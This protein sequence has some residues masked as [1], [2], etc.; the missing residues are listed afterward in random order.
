LLEATDETNARE[1]QEGISNRKYG[2]VTLRFNS[3]GLTQKQPTPSSI[4]NYTGL[5]AAGT[6]PPQTRPKSVSN[7][8]V[9]HEDDFTNSLRGNTPRHD[10]QAEVRKLQSFHQNKPVPGE[11][12]YAIQSQWITN[13]LLFVSKH[14]GKAEYAPGEI[15]NM[16]LI[17]DDLP[18][19]V[20]IVRP[21]LVLKKDFRMINKRSWDFYVAQY[22]GGPA[23]EVPVPRDCPD[24]TKWLTSL[25]LDEAG[26]VGS[27]Y[28]SS[29]S[30][31]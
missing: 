1:A 9:T 22:G 20:F 10:V 24:T 15:D 12:W 31:S 16:P 8:S 14:R 2:K 19:G 30:E 29:D 11:V 18:N 4:E 3:Y 5:M 23:I 6:P 21:N 27:G 17:S 7:G 28:F 13:W 25:R 26:R